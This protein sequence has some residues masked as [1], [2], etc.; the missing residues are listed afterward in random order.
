MVNTIYRTGKI[1]FAQI[2]EKRLRP[3]MSEGVEVVW[4]EFLH[5]V[6]M[7]PLSG[8]FIY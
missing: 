1:S 7:R 6:G 8:W 3:K 5:P 4:C 2:N